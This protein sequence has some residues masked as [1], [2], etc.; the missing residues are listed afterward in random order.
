M[1][2]GRFQGKGKRTVLDAKSFGYL[3]GEINL[4]FIA[5]FRV[6]FILI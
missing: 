1:I 4:G 2:K 5:S 3:A 6:N